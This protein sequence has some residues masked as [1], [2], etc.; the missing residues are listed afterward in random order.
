MLR[1]ERRDR[2][3]RQTTKTILSIV[4]TVLVI[5]AA[6]FFAV[7]RLVFPEKTQVTGP[8]EE[9]V[10][11]PAAEVPA[12]SIPSAVVGDETVEE[13]GAD[14]A[15]PDVQVV[16]HSAGTYDDPVTKINGMVISHTEW[17]RS[18]EDADAIYN[19]VVGYMS[20]TGY[21]FRE[22]SIENFD[23]EE[24]VYEL[25]LYPGDFR[26]NVKMPQ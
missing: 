2:Q 26:L 5:G 12:E 16:I 6:L 18:D 4:F 11:T 8:G 14:T 10:L 23:E 3:M 17:L 25:L 7:T 24:L 22:I 19:E 15:L 1:Q 9:I 13:Q 21:G 20:E